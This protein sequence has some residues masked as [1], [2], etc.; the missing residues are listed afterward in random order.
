MEK[1]LWQGIGHVLEE[2]GSVGE[3]IGTAYEYLK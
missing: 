1:Q 2:K 3:L